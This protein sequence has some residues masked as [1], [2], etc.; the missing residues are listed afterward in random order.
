[1][2]SKS[3]TAPVGKVSLRTILIVPF[4]IQILAAVGLTGY[5]SL[6]NGQ[7]AVNQLASQLRN[8]VSNRIDQH[9]TSYLSIAPRL[10]K[11]N[12]KAIAMRALDTKN[13]DQMGQFFWRQRTSFN[14]G[15]VMYGTKD[16]RYVGVGNYFGDQRINLDTVNRQ[17]HGN[18]H[19]YSYSTNNSGKAT[20]IVANTNE[21][22]LF[23]KEGWYAA[24]AALGK[25]TWS[26]V[27][28]WEV[29]PYTLSV[30]ASYPVFDA[31][32]KLTGVLAVEMPLS[33]VSEF[34]QQ[35]KASP[36]GKIFIIE[37]S[38]R[39][40]ASSSKEQPFRVEKGQKPQRLRASESEDP[41]IQASAKTLEAQIKNFNQIQTV[42][43]LEFF[44]KGKR[45]FL[46]VAPWRSEAG[47]DWL[48]V[49]VVPES[50]FMGQIDANTRTTIFLCVGALALA[51]LLGVYTSRWIT[52]PILRLSQ[53]SEAI[54]QGELD[55][56]VEASEVN[57]LG[58][59]AHSFNIMAGEIATRTRDL[60]LALEQQAISVQQVT[61][62]MD[63]LSTSARISAEQAEAA[64]AGA[65]QVLFLIDGTTDNSAINAQS[66]LRE[67]VEQLAQEILRLS[68]QTRQIGTISTLVSDLANQ[69]NMLAL[70]AAV[71]AA[72]A[73]QNGKGFNVIATEIRK[74][75]D[76][77]R[78]SGER[79]NA[80]VRDIHNATNSTV[81]VTKE[82]K[83]TVESVVNAV[84]NIS[85]NSQQISLNANQQ[86][87]AIGQ[88]LVAMNNLNQVAT[89]YRKN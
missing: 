36:S 12:H 60:Q 62:T 85:L 65:K 14:V 10:N 34:L 71:E 76:E 64:A 63:E 20:Q 11:I 40:I 47:L 46:Q 30:A 54:A 82:G 80:L 81:M 89:Q 41:L 77:S 45:Q 35:L 9:L 50:D 70:N 33:Q 7:K 27:Y 1:M 68:D 2:L 37:R 4:I 48:V 86:A 21:D 75:A 88:V 56:K 32:K 43:P 55:Q 38:G 8:E 87:V 44:F 16:G 57:E 78:A 17:R 58:R 51:I 3:A 53:A 28:N 19:F 61:T 15:Y 84:Y 52:R 69:T 67:K 5:L 22:Y 49:V 39:L 66:S 24:G 73:G 59:L 26:Q 6:R 13:L 74:L 18:A 79:I 31:K 72:R 42:K 25:P 29:E 23:Q 83:E